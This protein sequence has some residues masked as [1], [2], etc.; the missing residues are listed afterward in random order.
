[1]VEVQVGIGGCVVSRVGEADVV[2]EAVPLV[3]GRQA[4]SL[5]GFAAVHAVFSASIGI[6][7]LLRRPVS[8]W[9]NGDN[10][11]QSV[12]NVISGFPYGN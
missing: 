7:E 12:L 3:L 8:H 6:L 9:K 2:V 5:A 4:H 10:S 11:G 1:M